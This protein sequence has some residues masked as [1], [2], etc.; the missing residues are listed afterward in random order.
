MSVRSYHQ[1][2]IL[3]LGAN[4]LFI[5]LSFLYHG[6]STQGV[7]SAGRLF[8]S[9]TL[10]Y[11][12]S[13]KIDFDKFLS[14]SVKLISLNGL[15]IGIQVLEQVI[16]SDILPLILKYGGLWG[17]HENH[18]YEVFKKG[19]LLPSTQTSSL[20]CLFACSVILVK[21]F[22]PL[23][24]IPNL[25]GVFF[26]ARTT[27]LLI[28]ILAIALIFLWLGNVQLKKKIS[29]NTI[30]R[31]FL[32]LA[33][34]LFVCLFVAQLWFETGNGKQQLARIIQVIDVVRQVDFS[35]GAS[36]GTAFEYYRVPTKGMDVLFGNGHH[37]YHAAG[38]NDP[39]YSRWFIQSGLISIIFIFG[40]FCVFFAVERKTQRG[41]GLA[42]FLLSIQGL[43][44]EALTSVLF[45]DFYLIFLFAKKAQRPV[46]DSSVA[47]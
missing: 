1:L 41:R 9:S 11:F 46:A 19:G 25:I 47:G 4:F 22:N 5:C 36:D 45:F 28:F 10:I 17:F 15:L 35:G 32:K 27:F 37:R 24:Y 29:L 43:K 12:L 34:V 23:Y 21:K 3:I 18:D 40:M 8:L 33:L 14:I 2:L 39:L 42:I 26:G 7:T 31:K 6:N 44:G 16:G 20:W 13:T 38:G 30:G